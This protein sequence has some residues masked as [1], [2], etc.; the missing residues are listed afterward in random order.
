MR[1]ETSTNKVIQMLADPNKLDP[2]V[3]TK[4]TTE[5][6]VRLNGK[7]KTNVNEIYKKTLEVLKELEY[8][9]PVDGQKD[10]YMVNGN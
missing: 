6:S 4:L 10:K 2:T 1:F 7:H 3:R 5:K 9:I 8:L